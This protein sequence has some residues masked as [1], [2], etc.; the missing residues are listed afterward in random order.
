MLKV[1]L[2]VDQATRTLCLL[3]AV[4][5]IENPSGLYKVMFVSILQIPF[6]LKSK[7]K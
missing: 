3:E 4:Y 7:G 5:R 1:K 6:V 2:E